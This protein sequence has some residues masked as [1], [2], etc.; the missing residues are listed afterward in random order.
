[1]MMDDSQYY[2]Y[3]HQSKKIKATVEANINKENGR[4]QQQRNRG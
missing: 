1:M 2:N 4:Q 3:H